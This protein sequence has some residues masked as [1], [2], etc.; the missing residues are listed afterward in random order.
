MAGGARKTVLVETAVDVRILSQRAAQDPNGVVTAIAM[1][2]EFDT[3]SARE[4]VDTGAIKRGS[5]RVGV[6]RLTPLVEYASWWQ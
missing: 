6:Q 5:E 2:R 3:F 4:N 1:A